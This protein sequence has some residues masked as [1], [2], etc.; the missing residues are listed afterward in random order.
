MY[1]FYRNGRWRNDGN[2]LGEE[3]GVVV[4][5]VILGIKKRE[6]SGLNKVILYSLP[7]TLNVR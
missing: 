2:F 4:V 5:P 6:E 3:S 1:R 7:P